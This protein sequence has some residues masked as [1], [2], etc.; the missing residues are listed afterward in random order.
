VKPDDPVVSRVVVEADAGAEEDRRDVQVDL[1]D[2]ASLEQLPPDGRREH[3]D[4]LPAR[5]VEGDLH[6]VLDRAAEG[7]DSV[8]RPGVLRVVREYEDRPCHAPP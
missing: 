6:R 3:L 4:V 7:G 5:R 1:I 8:G 2:Q